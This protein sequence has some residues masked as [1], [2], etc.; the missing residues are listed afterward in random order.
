MSSATSLC[1]VCRERVKYNLTKRTY[2]GKCVCSTHKA[3]DQDN[4][5]HRVSGSAKHLMSW[6]KKQPAQGDFVNNK[7]L[8]PIVSD[9]SFSQHEK[10]A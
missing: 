10:D 4:I 3:N 8:T 5:I 2:G 1:T 9:N 7:R 6:N